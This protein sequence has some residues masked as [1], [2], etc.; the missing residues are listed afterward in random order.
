[1]TVQSAES[2]ILRPEITI[3][4]ISDVFTSRPNSSSN[5][6]TTYLYTVLESWLSFI[7]LR[8]CSC[9][10]AVYIVSRRYTGQLPSSQG[11]EW[12]LTTKVLKPI[13]LPTPSVVPLFKTDLRV[14]DKFCGATIFSKFPLVLYLQEIPAFSLNIS[15]CN[16]VYNF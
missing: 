2:G 15:G 8:T 4:N 12:V 9:D 3:T 7:G 5:L 1:M 11:R 10:G 13:V 6:R 14:E 16:F